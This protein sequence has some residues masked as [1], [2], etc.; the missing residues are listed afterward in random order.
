MRLSQLFSTVLVALVA[1]VALTLP[2][3]A[4]P[5]LP[6]FPV[7]DVACDGG[8]DPATCECL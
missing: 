8:F 6:H 2:V 1:L 5:K 3:S 7:C 4:S